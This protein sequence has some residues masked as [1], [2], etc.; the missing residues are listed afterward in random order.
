MSSTFPFGFQPASAGA[1]DSVIV[2]E[3]SANT[4][5]PTKVDFS[6]PVNDSLSFCMLHPLPLSANPLSRF[7]LR[8]L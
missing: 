7:L 2:A 3:A 1:L 5:K 6:I 4:T 8:G